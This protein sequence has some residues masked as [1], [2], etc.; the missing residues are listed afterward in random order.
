MHKIQINRNLRSGEF[1]PQRIAA[2]A[3]ITRDIRSLLHIRQG[4]HLHVRIRLKHGLEALKCCVDGAAQRGGSHQFDLVVVRE[5]LAQ[6]AALLVAEVREEGVRDDVV[7]CREVVDALE[8]VQSAKRVQGFGSRSK[9]DSRRAVTY[10]GVAN[11]VDDGRHRRGPI[12]DADGVTA[13]FKAVC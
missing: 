12:A 4:D 8:I 1:L 2:T 7:C 5:V 9:F 6:L 13:V 11:T 10:L 3:R